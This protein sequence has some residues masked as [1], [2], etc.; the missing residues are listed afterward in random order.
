MFNES[1]GIMGNISLSDGVGGDGG[2]NLESQG[3]QVGSMKD[4]KDRFA[5]ARSED[6]GFETV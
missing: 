2:F 4:R 1:Y 3:G 5:R 6:T